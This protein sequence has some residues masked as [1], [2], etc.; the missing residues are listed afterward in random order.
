V[1]RQ[2]EQV[3]DRRVRPQRGAERHAQR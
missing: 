2:T 3:N 1:R